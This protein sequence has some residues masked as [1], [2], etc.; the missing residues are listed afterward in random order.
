MIYLLFGDSIGCGF[1]DF[2]NGGWADMLGHFIDR[3]KRNH[4]HTLI[5]L[6]ISGDNSRRLIRRLENEAKLRMW[7]QHE[8]TIII[9]IGINDSMIEKGVERENVSEKEFE[10]NTLQV[11]KISK[12]LT[13]Y[14]VIVGITP[15]NEIKTKPFK[16]KIFYYANHTQKYN[17][18][19]Q[20]CARNE[21]V[22][23]IN[24]FS[25]MK[26]S[27]KEYTDDGLHPNTKGHK[28][29]YKEIKKSL[30]GK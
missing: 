24:L 12:M 1:L 13:K 4:D 19:L 2:E 5:N 25:K 23:F 26:N 17:L 11:I 16:R 20:R 21:K 6:S 8:H 15:V 22:K 18:I 27:I 29:M 3:D 7:T 10:K 30:F 14:I 9:A 28:F